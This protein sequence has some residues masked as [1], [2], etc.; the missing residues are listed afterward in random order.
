MGFQPRVAQLLA[1]MTP[2]ELARA[3]QLAETA[4]L[5]AGVTFS[6][7]ATSSMVATTPLSSFRRQ[8]HALAIAFS[9]CGSTPPVSGTMPAGGTIFGRPLRLRMVSGTN[10]RMVVGVLMLLASVGARSFPG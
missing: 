7:R 9:T 10:T 2:D 8:L 3:Q 6:V 1:K 4:L 5:Q